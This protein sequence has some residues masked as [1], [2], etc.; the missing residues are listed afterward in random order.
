MTPGEVAV[1]IVGTILTAMFML[2]LFNLQSLRRNMESVKLDAADAVAEAKQT[3]A[4]AHKRLDV[5]EQRQMEALAAI[6]SEMA[7]LKD[8]YIDRFQEV[9][10]NI[11]GVEKRLTAA[12]S[13]LKL[14]LASSGVNFG[15]HNSNNP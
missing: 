15:N 10:E 12:I 14:G 7:Q 3:A 8:N 2:N 4:D 11:N 13:E 6:N 5:H 1:I 9:N